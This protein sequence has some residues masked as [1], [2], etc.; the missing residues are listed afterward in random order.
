[1]KQVRFT[2]ISEDLHDQIMQSKKLT[3]AQKAITLQL[4]RLYN[5]KNHTI[6]ISIRK[7]AEQ[8]CCSKNTVRLAINKLVETGFL[9][10]VKHNGKGK[11]GGDYCHYKLLKVAANSQG[12]L[13]CLKKVQG[14]PKI[15]TL[16]VPKNGTPSNTTNHSS[17]EADTTIKH[18]YEDVGGVP[19]KGTNTTSINK[20]KSLN[21]RNKT[22]PPSLNAP[23]G[24]VLHEDTYNK[25]GEALKMECDNDNDRF[26]KLVRKTV[27]IKHQ[28]NDLLSELE[29]LPDELAMSKTMSEIYLL[30]D[31]LISIENDLK[32]AG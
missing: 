20:R 2:A 3:L 12:I 19:K 11:N 29:Y 6:C 22:S 24:D 26:W 1:M 13:V 21:K 16:G 32:R 5:R 23:E 18:D 15:A 30:E 8:C 28:I 17:Y 31:K 7:I 10:K 4:L 14:V 9:E 25:K 27:D